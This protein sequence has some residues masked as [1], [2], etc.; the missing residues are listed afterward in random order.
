MPAITIVSASV[1]P[2][3]ALGAGVTARTLYRRLASELGFYAATAT[4]AQAAAGDPSRVLLA[5]ELRDDE[6]GSQLHARDWVYVTS[7][8]AAGVQRRLLAPHEAGYQGALGALVVSRPFA[9]P[10]PAGSLVEVTSPLPVKR[11][12]GVMGLREAIDAALALIMIPLRLVVVGNGTYEYGLGDYPYLTAA[13]QVRHVSDTGALGPTAPAAPSGAPYRIVATGVARTLVPSTL[14]S[15]TQT[16]VL[17]VVIPADRYVYDGSAWTVVAVNGVPGLQG[18]DW[19]TAAPADWV[20]AFGMVKAL[21][22]VSKLLLAAGGRDPAERQLLLAETMGRRQTWARTAADVKW[23]AFPRP[24][25]DVQ[26]V[27]VGR[28]IRASG[29]VPIEQA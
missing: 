2:S 16:F 10:V 4:T 28:T 3:P 21:Q 27:L 17:D 29:S 14:Y 8:A 6:V 11:H 25:Q 23:R 15:A 12:L 18:D 7:G 19:A 5:E 1:G 22:A 20:H 9:A 26:P 24:V 13:E